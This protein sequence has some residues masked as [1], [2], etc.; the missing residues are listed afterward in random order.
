MCFDFLTNFP[1]HPSQLSVFSLDDLQIS[2][3]AMWQEFYD[4]YNG[5][6]ERNITVQSE[7]Y[8]MVLYVTHFKTNVLEKKIRGSFHTYRAHILQL[9]NQT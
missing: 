1:P 2:A 5:T 3:E 6:L 8:N 4:L 7:C 9:A